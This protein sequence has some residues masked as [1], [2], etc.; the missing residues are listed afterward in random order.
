[1]TKVILISNLSLPYAKIGSWTTL[2]HNYIAGQHQVD[3]IICPEP[4]T[5]YSGITYGFAVRDRLWK[6]RRR[7]FGKDYSEYFEPLKKM[8]GPEQRYVIQVIDNHGMM[9]HLGKFLVRNGL[10]DQCYVQFFHHGFGAFFNN[11]ESKAFFRHMDEM[12]LLTFESYNFY[13]KYYADLPCRF[14]V[15]HNGID[16][17]KF[18]VP[19]AAKKKELKDKFDVVGKQVFLWCSQDRPKK[20]LDLI[21]NVWKMVYKKHEN[22]ELWIVG[23]KRNSIIGGVTFL[24]GI[25]N[26]DLPERYQA[27]DVYLFPTLV[28]EGFGM[29]LVE[30]LHCGNYCIASSIGGVPEVL[31]YGKLGMLIQ[32]PNF[33]SE[34]VDAINNYLQSG[35]QVPPISKQLYSTSQWNKGMNGLISDAKNS[36]AS[37]FY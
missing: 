27:A 34:W 22:I 30:A 1:M 31:Q 6:I 36:I 9:P 32:N 37:N 19:D 18:F 28:Q 13:K 3:Y 15:L 4:D 33:V 2:Y 25:P 24:G 12:V 16:T 20:G 5:P 35:K 8:I 11:H 23:A 21:L 26:N 7:L 17:N 10:R 14:S 29:A